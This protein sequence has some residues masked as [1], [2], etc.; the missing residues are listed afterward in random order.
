MSE[1]EFMDIF[2]DNLRDLM[3]EVGVGQNQLAREIGVSNQTI[4]YYINKKRMPSLP[5]FINICISLNCD[6]D[7]LVPMYDYI[8]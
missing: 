2:G 5:T 4:S 8:Y 7:D 1:V 3:E 6:P